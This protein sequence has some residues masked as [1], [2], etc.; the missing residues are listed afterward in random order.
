MLDARLQDAVFSFD[1][2]RDAGLADLDA[3]LDTI[4]FHQRLGTMADKRERLIAGVRALGEAAGVAGDDLSHAEAAARL[5]KAD[6]GAVLVAEF[7]DLEGFVA[8]EYARAEGHPEEVARAVEEQYLP[9]GAGTSPP[10]GI[11]GALLAAAE[12]IDNLVGAFAVDEAP[13]GSKDPYALRRA[14]QGLVRILLDRGWDVPTEALLAGAHARLSEQGA[15]LLLDEASTRGALGEFMDDR[16]A[17]FLGEEGIAHDATAAAVGAGLG[18]VV[19]AVTWARG[20]DAARGARVPGGGSRRARTAG[21][22]RGELRRRATGSGLTRRRRRGGP[23]RGD[24]I[25]PPGD[26][27]RA[28]GA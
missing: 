13:T 6:Q 1:K 27:G 3:R 16:V 10:S 24:R 18:S 28:D 17:Y 9:A 4:V 15:D 20:L 23:P 8:A 7:S 19:A 5:A 26:R 2:D 14:A 21:Q 22:A 12:K 11:P 25:R